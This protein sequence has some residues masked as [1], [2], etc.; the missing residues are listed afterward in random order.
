MPGCEGCRLLKNVVVNKNAKILG[1]EG[2]IELNISTATSRRGTR[3][4]DHP[5]L[6]PL[7]FVLVLV[8]VLHSKWYGFTLKP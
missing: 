7:I 8:L 5:G 2:T 1:L 4:V 3:Q 6:C